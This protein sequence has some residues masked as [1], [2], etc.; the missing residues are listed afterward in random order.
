M[1]QPAVPTAHLLRSPLTV[2]VAV[3]GALVGALVGSLAGT[4][5]AI[6][7]AVLGA[8]IAVGVRVAASGAGTPKRASMDPFTLQE[9]WRRLVQD[10]LG[11][12]DR[13]HRAVDATAPGPMRDRVEE[14]GRRVDAAVAEVW[15][16][17]RAGHE[18][19]T[20]RRELGSSGPSADRLDERIA[21]TE[22]R[23]RRVDD[24]LTETI[25][26]AIELSVSGRDDFEPIEERVASIT[27]ELGA[28]R[29][30]IAET[31]GLG[32][33]PGATGGSAS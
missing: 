1:N 12:R 17:A 3:A 30:A 20:A 26:L 5:T 19:A 14:L 16:N 27:D 9:P 28:I 13:F 31:R 32:G 25:G 8:F 33:H 6:V 23:L 7:L 18:L 22:A 2:A 10:A 21:A 11:A 15:H 4:L 24:R 29:E